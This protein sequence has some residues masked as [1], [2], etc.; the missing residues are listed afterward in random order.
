MVTDTQYV[1]D[2]FCKIQDLFG[3]LYTNTDVQW[4][5]IKECM[6][7][8]ISDLVGKVEKRGENHGLHRK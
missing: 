4:N 8:N 6:L 7:D 3:I 5:N 1:L 2:T